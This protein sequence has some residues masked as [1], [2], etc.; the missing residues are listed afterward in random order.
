M[1]I[2][3]QKGQRISLAK[4]GGGALS[5]VTMGLGWDGIEV[6]GLFGKPKRKDIDL[7]ASCAMFDSGGRLADVVWWRQLK[8]KDGSIIHTGDNVTGA[9]EGDDESI[10]VDL[11]RVPANV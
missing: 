2:D 4:E 1:P 11:N 9:G 6:K 5:R 10:I 3:M 7:D 8:S